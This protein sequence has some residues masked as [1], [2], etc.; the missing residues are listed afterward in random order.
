MVGSERMVEEADLPSLVYTQAVVKETFRKHNPAPL[1]LQHM[2]TQACTVLGYSLPQGTTLLVNAWA[3][4]QDP[5]TWDDPQRF[6]PERFLGAACREV[7]VCGQHF[8]LLPFGSGRRSCPG[9]SLALPIVQLTVSSLIHTFQWALP[10]DDHIIDMSENFG[11]V[12]GPRSPLMAIPSLRLG[13]SYR[14]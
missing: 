4:G 7:D 8:E 14:P 6:W 12:V 9:M 1:L 11:T 3:I 5:Q 2:S 13:K 10:S